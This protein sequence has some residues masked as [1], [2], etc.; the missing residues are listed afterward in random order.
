MTR[1]LVIE[2]DRQFCQ[3]L[4]E[5]LS[6]EGISVKFAHD[7]LS[8]SALALSRQYDLV[9][10]NVELPEFRGTQLIRFLRTYSDMGV[11]LLSSGAAEMDKIVGLECGADDY[12]VKPFNPQELVARIR[13]IGRHLTKSRSSSVT[14]MPEYFHVGDLL[15]DEGTRTCRRNGTL[16][17]LTTAE[18][19]LLSTLL[20]WRGRVVHRRDLSKRVLDREHSPI[21][22]SI[23]VLACNLRRKL[24]RLPDGTERI[25]GVR[26]V[27]YMYAHPAASQHLLQEMSLQQAS[28][29]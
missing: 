25:R 27:G 13:A 4:T 28:S 14:P 15:L 22:R 23:D 6:Q 20:R 18:F 29:R 21:D 11:L 9:V 17:E 24:G 2:H 12:L 19:N 1:V 10:W 5:H 7:S 26:S 16:V 8:G 3:Q